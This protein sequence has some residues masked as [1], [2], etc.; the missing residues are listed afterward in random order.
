MQHELHWDASTISIGL[1]LNVMSYGLGQSLIAE[2][3][4]RY[5]VRP[6]LVGSFVVLALSSAALFFVGGSP[7]YFWIVYG[8]I[9]GVAFAGTGLVPGTELVASR[10][11]R[12]LASRA[13]G[14]LSAS[15]PAGQIVIVP[16][17]AILVSTLGFRWAFVAI[18]AM[19]AILGIA[20]VMTAFRGDPA[21]LTPP[22]PRR[23]SWRLVA[24]RP[25]LLLAAGYFACGFTDQMMI[26]HLIPLVEH[27]GLAPLPASLQLSILSGAGLVGSVGAGLLFRGMPPRISLGCNYL[28]RAISYIF[29]VAGIRPLRPAFLVIFAVVFGL[30]LIS[31]QALSVPAALAHFGRQATAGVMGNL[32]TIHH[33]AGALGIGLAGFLYDRTGSYISA[34]FVAAGVLV[35]ASAASF[36]LA[37]PRL[38]EASVPEGAAFGSTEA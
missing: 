11:A 17:A 38:A 37:A 28:V 14:L 6:V 20:P 13:T 1:A 31:N 4:R 26:A 35:V 29:L 24:R 7:W 5:T 22:E 34:L 19:V 33:L 18:G 21:R 16:I 36:S 9:P 3:I 30:T 27:A 32:L 2:L 15:L 25:F 12:Q 10:F 23:S 8:F